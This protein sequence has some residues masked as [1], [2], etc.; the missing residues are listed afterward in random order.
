VV[1]VICAA[2]IAVAFAAAAVAWAVVMLALIARLPPG[3][4]RG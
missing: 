4:S 1:I 2:I 3:R